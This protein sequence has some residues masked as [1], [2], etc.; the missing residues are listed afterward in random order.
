MKQV[1]AII[2]RKDLALGDEEK[3]IFSAHL[4]MLEDPEYIDQV[5]EMISQE[6][7]D[8][9]KAVHV[10]SHRVA[11][12][13][14]SLPDPYLSQRAGDVI[15]I[16]LRIIR[17]VSGEDQTPEKNLEN[18]DIIIL[19]RDIPPSAVP[20]LDP[21]RVQA[22]IAEEG[23]ATSHAAI[24]LKNLEI[25]AVFGTKGIHLKDLHGTLLMV[26]GHA[27]KVQV[28]PSEPEKQAFC[29]RID[30]SHRQQLE[31][32][33]LATHPGMTAD[34]ERVHL[35]ANIGGVKELPLITKFNP[36]G[37]GL[38]RTEFLF[39]H[40]RSAPSES[41]QTEIYKRTLEALGPRKAIIRTL[42][43]G[44][45]KDVPYLNL[46]KE[47]NPF[48]GLR[49]LRYCLHNEAV[50]R[51]QLRALLRASPYG[52][53][54]IMY[55]MVTTLEELESANRILD[56]EREKLV[57]AGVQVAPDIKVGIMIEVPAAAMMADAF[58]RRVDFIS[59]GTNDLTQYTCACDRLNPNVKSL[60]DPFEPAVLRLI[61]MVA[62]A[63]KRSKINV[64][65][66]G[67]MGGN[68][69]IA[70]F[71]LG[72]GITNLSMSPPLIP[73]LKASLSTL[74]ARECGAIAEEALAST[75]ARAVKSLLDGVVC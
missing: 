9:T 21:H 18:Q 57:L 65:V 2:N 53:L 41:E 44:G 3:Q 67:E 34:N 68:P 36:D 54:H 4:M 25:P 61:N 66:C 11:D 50:F 39:L 16:G 6:K 13:F 75:S 14:A 72:I 32:A 70:P 27:G 42:D 28:N 20:E 47:E 19:C 62:E 15:D 24:L 38:F 73:R 64:S 40:R 10:V 26:D 55:P 71:F 35:L 30:Q 49:G 37:I 56:E 52:N 31:L 51:T 63:G 60:Y 48:L 59:L 22:V 43:I 7:Y 33:K 5:R 46:P 17:N 23:G 12:L 58:A 29:N 69:K 45:D 8:A 74:A 1:E